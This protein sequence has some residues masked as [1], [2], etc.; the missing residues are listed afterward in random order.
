MHFVIGRGIYF[1][2][3]NLITSWSTIKTALRKRNGVQ[4][5]LRSTPSA[6]PYVAEGYPDQ[7]GRVPKIATQA[8]G[9]AANARLLHRNVG[10][11]G[12]VKDLH[13]HSRPLPV[14]AANN[15]Y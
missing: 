7:N 6:V 10:R 14:G 12:A 2:M 9:R 13:Q 5:I 11:L 8:H 1:A 15:A 3:T 4:K